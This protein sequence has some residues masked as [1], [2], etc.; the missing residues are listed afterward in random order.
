MKEVEERVM[1]ALYRVD[2][3]GDYKFTLTATDLHWD[4]GVHMCDV[5][6]V[7]PLLFCE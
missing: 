3:R 5:P 7:S 6:E 1:A 2:K 4:M